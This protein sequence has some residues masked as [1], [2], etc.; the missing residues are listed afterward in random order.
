MVTNSLTVNSPAN[1]NPF[2]SFP[3]SDQSFFASDMNNDG[4]C[5]LIGIAPVTIPTGP[6]SNEYA[7]YVYVYKASRTSSG[8]I[9]YLTGDLYETPGSFVYE[10][11][12]N[13]HSTIQGLSSTLSIDIDGNGVNELLIPYFFSQSGNG[14]S[15][16]ILLAGDDY[17]IPTIEEFDLLKSEMPLYSTGD[18]NNDGCCDIVYIEN[19]LVNGHYPSST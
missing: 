19:E 3:F 17:P 9:E 1:I 14:S 7:T 10:S 12:L 11:I 6:N 5:D 18:L 2:V 8:N 16:K 4:L 13:S 15:L